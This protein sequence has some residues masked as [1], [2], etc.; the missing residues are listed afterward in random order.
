MPQVCTPST[1]RN[2]TMMAAAACRALR[3]YQPAMIAAMNPASGVMAEP[4][5]P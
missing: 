1:T 4:P 5:I 2:G 3:T